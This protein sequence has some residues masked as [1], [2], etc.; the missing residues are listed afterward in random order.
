M[1]SFSA[2]CTEAPPTSRVTEADEP[3]LL[4]VGDPL[5]HHQVVAV[6]EGGDPVA[7]ADVQ[8]GVEDVVGVGAARQRQ[9]RVHVGEAV[10]GVVADEGVRVVA[11]ALAQRRLEVGG[12]EERPGD[13]V[14]ARGE[15][16]AGD[17][18]GDLQG[19]GPGGELAVGRRAA[20]LARAAALTRGRLLL[21][22]PVHLHPE[23]GEAGS[24]ILRRWRASAA[25]RDTCGAPWS[26]AFTRNSSPPT[27]PWAPRASAAAMRT[28]G[29][30]S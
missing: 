14:E 20:G 6:A 2:T 24:G 18:L 1:R 26:T 28:L 8:E 23:P 16:L 12:P 30:S 9:D 10:D 4:V 7:V 17:R 25:A 19:R 27:S 13:G 5:V 15:G 21:L 11:G 22:G 3:L 29:A